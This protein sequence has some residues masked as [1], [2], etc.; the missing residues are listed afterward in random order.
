MGQAGREKVYAAHTWEIKCRM[1]EEIY[2]QLVQ[3]AARS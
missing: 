2:Q 1:V 3:T